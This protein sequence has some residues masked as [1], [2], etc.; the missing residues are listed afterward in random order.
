MNAFVRYLAVNT[1]RAEG[2]AEYYKRYFGLA[3]VARSAE[4]DIALSDGWFK[5]CLRAHWTDDEIAGMSHYGIAVDSLDELQARLKQ[6]GP[7]AEIGKGRGGDFHGDYFV[8]DPHGMPWAISTRN[9]GLPGGAS[10]PFGVPRIRHAEL[11]V[12]DTQRE[13]QWMNDVFGLREVNSSVKIRAAGS[14]FAIRP[15]ANG[16]CSISA[17]WCPI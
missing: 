14:T 7:H 6:F 13:M 8:L 5:L 1:P 10:K 4:G 17:G 3:E 2:M 11:S 9:F 16:P 12:G 15:S